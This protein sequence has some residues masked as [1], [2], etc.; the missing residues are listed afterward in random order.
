MPGR[1]LLPAD[2]HLSF[3]ADLSEA[4]ELW[5]PVEPGGPDRELVAVLYAA[6]DAPTHEPRPPDGPPHEEYD[7]PVV[8]RERRVRPTPRL[9]IRHMGFGYATRRYGLDAVADD[10]LQRLAY[11][12][13]GG[14]DHQLLG[15]PAVVQDDPRDDGDVALFHLGNDGE[16]RFDFLDGGDLLFFGSADAIKARDWE[17]LTV[18]PSSS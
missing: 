10:L 2:G 4:A 1:E 5:E 12:I 16:L 6:P 7:A 13:N 3:F 9:Q 14:E 18:W 15:Y 8:L 11:S 17:R